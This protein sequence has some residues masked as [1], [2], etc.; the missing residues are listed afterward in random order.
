ME[1]RIEGARSPWMIYSRPYNTTVTCPRSL[2]DGP[3]VLCFC[4]AGC[5]LMGAAAIVRLTEP[6]GH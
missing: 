3:L 6:S 4:F 2:D 5:G 1:L